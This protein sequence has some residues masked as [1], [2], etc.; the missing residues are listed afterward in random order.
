[1]AVTLAEKY[2]DYF[3]IGAAVNPLLIEKYGALITRQFS[4]LTCENE[5]KFISVHT[6]NGGYVFDAADT[7]ANFAREN[8]IPMR[9][10]T[11]VWHA[12]TPRWIFAE[13]EAL[14]GILKDHIET[15]SAKYSDLIYTWDVVNEA[16][17]D[18]DGGA[19]LRERNPWRETLGND[20]LP[21]VFGIAKKVLP[22]GVQL[23]YNDYNEIDPG[24]WDALLRRY[25]G[26]TQKISS[27]IRSACSA[28]GESRRR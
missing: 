25:G 9:G 12:Q 4:S 13:K 18:D 28:I 16:V 5:M 17:N 21:Y 10:H 23:A 1:M 22:E 14:P 19:T 15:V 27:W 3:K 2:R 11:F 26:S 20:Y 24:K 6:E 7:V 8:K